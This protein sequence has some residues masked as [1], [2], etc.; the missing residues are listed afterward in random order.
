M[1]LIQFSERK[2]ADNA[3]DR[4]PGKKGVAMKKV[5]LTSSSKAFLERNMNLLMNKGFQFF[6]AT[7]GTETLKLHREYLFDL[8]LSELE[9]DDM[10]G[11]TLCT[12]VR[13]AEPSR[14]VSVVLICSDTAE[15]L[16]KAERCGAA[17][18]LVRPLKPT[19]LLV[20]IGSI[21]DMQLARSKRVEF[22]SDV[23]VK[24]QTIEF[25]SVSRD[26]S[27][28]GILI[29]SDHQL[30]LGDRISCQFRLFDSCHTQTE[31]EVARCVVSP[32]SR[33]LYGVK[34]IDLSSQGR[35]AI[36]RYVALNDHLGIRLAVNLNQST[37]VSVPTGSAQQRNMVQS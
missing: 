23:V 22:I 32:K 36:G 30:D 37:H 35:N 9:L 21:I 27:T 17:A 14:P 18:I 10:N 15:N 24:K 3:F 29:E 8:I 1:T 20:T 2:T 11:C 34:F 5:L 31:A 28:T 6:T 33:K 25:H 19:Q 7:T 4:F 13:K 26:I 12:E 16:E